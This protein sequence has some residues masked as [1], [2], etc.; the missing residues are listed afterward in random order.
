MASDVARAALVRCCKIDAGS[1]PGRSPATPECLSADVSNQRSG[2]PASDSLAIP[3][4]VRLT[5]PITTA[6]DGGSVQQRLSAA[7]TPQ[8]VI[9]AA[10]ATDKLYSLNVMAILAVISAFMVG[11][12]FKLKKRPTLRAWLYACL[13]VPAFVLF[14]EFVMPYQGGGAS[15]WPVA[16]VFGGIYGAIAGGAGV[17]L[18]ALVTRR[19]NEHI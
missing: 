11:F 13:V 3:I 6:G 19:S 4:P 16:L 5:I 2:R 7:A 18:A 8:P 10:G 12:L 15:M 1:R 9:D 14:A 17:G